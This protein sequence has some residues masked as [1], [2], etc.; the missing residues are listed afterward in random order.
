MTEPSSTENQ[1]Y[2]SLAALGDISFMGRNSDN[3]TIDVFSAVSHVFQQSD[4][5]VANLESPL[6]E[7]GE[8]VLHK[9]VLKAGIGWAQV[10]RKAGIRVVSLANN[11]I[12]DYGQDGLLSTIEALKSAGITFLGAGRNK[13]EACRPAFL[14]VGGRTVAMLARSSVIVSSPT[15]ATDTSSGTAFLDVEETKEALSACKRHADIVILLMHW[16]LEEYQY[17]S[18]NQR[19]LGKEFITAGV[20]LILGHHPHV[21]QG[22]E[23]IGQS[24]I[25]YSLG[26]FVFDE[27]EWICAIPGD[28]QRKLHIRLSDE[29]RRGIILKANLHEDGR[30]DFSGLF[31]RIGENCVVIPDAEPGRGTQFE[32]YARNLK[33][34]FYALGWR[35]YSIE[36]EWKLR[37]WRTL[38]LRRVAHNCCKL[39]LN[40]ITGLL[41]AFRRSVKIV[42]GKSTNPYD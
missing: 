18:P 21:L 23:R 5:V 19:T 4:I 12:M 7:T 26:N 42:T 41:K 14:A 13:E 31:T 33:A 35:L 37:L 3:P 22:I 16:G 36:M 32:R 6:T 40:H 17:P 11:H 38:S 2:I 24:I 1:P 8:P 30:L 25:A 28:K 39:R 9:C 15:Y 27:F 20:D 10:M 29:N 34:P